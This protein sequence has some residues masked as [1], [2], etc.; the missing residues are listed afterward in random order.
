[1]KK[2]VI[3]SLLAL[4]STILLFAQN[5]KIVVIPSQPIEFLQTLYTSYVFGTNDFE[6]IKSHFDNRI[7]KK[8]KDA[9][10]YDGDGY[11]TWL[12]R[13]GCQD[14]PS[15]ES[16]V[17]EIIPQK[18]NWFQ[19]SYSDMGNKGKTRFKVKKAKGKVVVED[20]EEMKKE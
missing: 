8:L 17:L 20:F 19:V 6:E 18:D 16:S 9:Y 2:L 7:I 10:V 13:T 1:M 3:A 11:A 14:G 15:D 5:E 4:T 12:F